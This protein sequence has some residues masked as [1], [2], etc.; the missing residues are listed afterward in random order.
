MTAS[1]L[2][3]PFIVGLLKRM[4][5]ESLVFRP[6]HDGLALP[7][8]NASTTTFLSLTNIID[9][10]LRR[11]LKQRI[12]HYNPLFSD[13]LMLNI[14][15]NE[16]EIT[17]F[18]NLK[19]IYDEL[20][21]VKEPLTRYIKKTHAINQL[22]VNTVT[23]YVNQAHHIITFEQGQ[24]KNSVLKK[25]EDNL[26]AISHVS[27][28]DILRDRNAIQR[29]ADYQMK[30][31]LSKI[32]HAFSLHTILWRIIV[33]PFKYWTH[34]T[35]RYIH[36]RVRIRQQLI[37][38]MRNNRELTQAALDQTVDNFFHRWLHCTSKE[39]LASLS[40][41]E[42]ESI[43]SLLSQEAIRDHILHSTVI[44]NDIKET[45]S[46]DP[47]SAFKKMIFIKDKK[48][49]NECNTETPLEKSN[50]PTKS[51][52]LKRYPYPPSLLDVL[53]ALIH[54]DT[55]KQIYG[56]RLSIAEGIIK[57]AKPSPLK[58]NAKRLSLL[59]IYQ[60]RVTEIESM[61]LTMNYDFSYLEDTPYHV[62]FYH[63]MVA[64]ETFCD[65]HQFVLN[66]TKEGEK[67]KCILLKILGGL[68]EMKNPMI[69]T[70]TNQTMTSPS[71]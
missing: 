53:N 31:V 13:H 15:Q 65:S 55:A 67:L 40:T 16:R 6:Y 36:E 32:N 30:E 48:V 18:F 43:K 45:L 63:F 51:T 39:M 35:F 68:K 62:N 34:K 27:F 8:D 71:I 7:C 19:R 42:K 61:L 21:I 26:N 20:K 60:K 9:N 1:R 28:T 49:M 23:E 37:A 66:E 56:V 12:R 44:P 54:V 64:L 69:F 70:H 25:V 17:R 10:H 38:L 22:P 46:I 4:D 41:V 50:Q 24:L 57:Y 52:P 47:L 11:Q 14:I 5:W 3:N 59:N 29:Y 2:S 33:N 58:R